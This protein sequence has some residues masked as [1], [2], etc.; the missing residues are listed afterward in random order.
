M[1]VP[2]KLNVLPQS[3]RMMGLRQTWRWS[4]RRVLPP[5]LLDLVSSPSHIP[6]L[7]VEFDRRHGTDTTGW[8]PT[9]L[10]GISDTHTR[11]QA[12][13]YATAP[14]RVPRLLLASLGIDPAEFT[15]VDYGCGKGRVLLVASELP[16]TKVVGVEISKALSDIARAN[17][18]KFSSPAQRCTDIEVACVD[19]REYRLPLTDTVF[20][21]YNPFN[22]DI[23]A[24]VLTNLEQSLKDSPRRVYIVY[25]GAFPKVIRAFAEYRFLRARRLVQCL[26]DEYS[27]AL[28]SNE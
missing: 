6:Y 15:F 28:F 24:S 14:A 23:L 13:V 9:R 27:W 12:A 1:S 17:V 7:D 16:F 10:L 22:T 20:Y 21:L 26:N 3:V 5:P 8:V 2:R 4:L 18:S 11:E 19:A 25:L